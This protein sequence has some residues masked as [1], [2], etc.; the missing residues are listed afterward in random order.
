MDPPS[1]RNPDRGRVEPRGAALC[2]AISLLSGVFAAGAM[3]ADPV[4]GR[5]AAAPADSSAGRNAGSP[6]LYIVEPIVV[7]ADKYAKPILGFA[8]SI[9]VLEREDL[10]SPAPANLAALIAGVPGLYAYDLNGSGGAPV[11][12]V[13][14]FTG[15]G[16]AEYLLVTLDGAPLNGLENGLADWLLM[17]R[18]IIERIEVVRGPASALYGDVGLGGL[19][20]VTTR[21]TLDRAWGGGLSAEG[22]SF[23]EMRYRAG[24]RFGHP[25]ASGN[26]ALWHQRVDGWRQHSAYLGW[27]TLATLDRPWSPASVL[28]LTVLAGDVERED[29]GPVAIDATGDDRRE[30]STPYDGL[31]QRHLLLSAHQD[32]RTGSGHEVKLLGYIRAEDAT[33]IRTIIET[34]EQETRER[35][36]GFETRW[37]SPALPAPAGGESR[38]ASGVQIERGT[39]DSRY[40][41]APA[42]VRTELTASGEDT[43]G[44]QAVYLHGVVPVG[45]WEL[46]LSARYDRI[47]S[48]FE[49]GDSAAEARTMSA[50]SPKLALN[51]RWATGASA[52]V[53][54]TRGFKAP[55]LQQLFDQRRP[56]GFDLANPDLEPQRAT[57]LEVGARRDVG[58]IPFAA[59]LF[60]T[61]V[62][63]EI[64]FDLESFTYA[65]IGKSLH[66]GV[67]TRWGPIP[68]GPLE[69]DL[70]YTY[71]DARFQAGADAG[72][73][74]NNVPR[75][76]GSGRIGWDLWARWALEARS[77]H[78]LFADEANQIPIRGFTTLDLEVQHELGLLSWFVAARN[79]FD[80]E[81]AGAGYV[82]VQAQPVV[83]PAAG[84]S[85]TAGVTLKR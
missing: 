70:S 44:T 82:D 57:T 62:R 16:E 15:Q 68:C 11:A 51:Y 29:P 37:V 55:T 52:Y 8:G 80:R 38:L 81:Y 20:N 21:R 34:K 60:T 13:R 17:D 35:T 23:G 67:E 46:Q 30:A 36:L 59:N 50:L 5:G 71:L 69:L 1:R 39:L 75:H 41:D 10:D 2:V 79:L 54:L 61:T 49:E 3:A 84:R 45:R 12:D 4:P 26:L 33:Q 83:F 32:W 47:H 73:Q 66:R 25:A 28:H 77:V 31:D 56:L 63:D 18:E 43:R 24:L 27:H 42:G 48:R 22:G 9:E 85:I 14:G 65:N 40:Y 74:I 7:T 58:R 53:A 72:N 78:G 76:I 6:G 19:V 64:G